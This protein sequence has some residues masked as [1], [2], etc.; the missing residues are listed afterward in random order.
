MKLI[1][2]ITFLIL[3]I[4]LLPGHL[5]SQEQST[6]VPEPD[7][8]KAAP[9]ALK[10]KVPELPPINPL[11]EQDRGGNIIDDNGSLI[12]KASGFRPR[13]VPVF[14]SARAESSV[15]VNSAGWNAKSTVT[16]DVVQGEAKELTLDLIGDGDIIE[17]SGEGILDWAVRQSTLDGKRKGTSKSGPRQNQE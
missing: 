16:F 9:K 6:P 4:S 1:K 13:P 2:V 8:V 10:E 7:Q 14:Y 3:S 17:V 12:I 5:H 11:P 15:N